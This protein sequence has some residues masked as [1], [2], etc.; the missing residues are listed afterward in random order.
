MAKRSP[1]RPPIDW[2]DLRFVLAVADS[3]SLNR[4]ASALRVNRTTVLRR[5]NAF[6]Q[7]HGV[8]L[9]DRLPNG[10]VLTPA[11]D[12]I[13]T[14]ARGFENV[15]VSLERKLAGQDLRPEGLVR[16]T[17]TDTLLNSVLTGALDEFQRTYPGI[18]LDVTS[19]NAFANLSKRDADV[20]IRPVLDPPE[21]LIG[22]RI[23]GVAFAVY[24]AA[25]GGSGSVADDLARE[26]WLGPDDTLAGTSVA[27]WMRSA[28]P[29]VR[30]AIR[31][32]SLV[33]LRE[34]C[35]AGLG[36][37]ALP[38]YLGDSDA[39]LVR[40]RAPVDEM[41]TALWVLTHP[42]LARTARVRLFMDRVSASL[43]R[44]RALLEGQRPRM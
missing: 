18:T 26:R 4:A 1:P 29:A 2:D 38:C 24:A 39:R 31:T 14:A 28:L 9:F 12:E 16:V 27:Q 22:R 10:Y 8:R 43:R 34:L 17:T 20:A 7:N 5:I 33:S 44:E 23:G 30:P 32:D 3:G 35:A 15:I 41:A 13:L 25:N 6:E 40:V 42:D 37:A 21:F 19:G 11:G 36:L